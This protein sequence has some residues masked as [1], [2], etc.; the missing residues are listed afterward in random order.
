[1]KNR[2]LGVALVLLF[3]VCTWAQ[4][5]DPAQITVDNQTTD[6]IFISRLGAP[7]QHVLIPKRIVRNVDV[8]LVAGVA[9][10]LQ[11]LQ[12]TFPTSIIIPETSRA[13]FNGTFA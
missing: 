13:G 6:S 9:E 10:S 7:D 2:E 11:M 4:Q 1:M 12:V 8:P 3:P 5:A